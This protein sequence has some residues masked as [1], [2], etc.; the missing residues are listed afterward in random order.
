MTSETTPASTLRADLDACLLEMGVPTKRRQ[1]AVRQ[2]C[3]GEAI[4]LACERL[5]MTTIS[6]RLGYGEHTIRKWRQREPEFNRRLSEALTASKGSRR[7]RVDA[8]LWEKA[9]SMEKGT[10]G[11]GQSINILANL[12]FPELRESKVKAE[13]TGRPEPQAERAA[14]LSLA[15]RN[16]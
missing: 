11:V 10:P 5:S 14:L 15:K 1:E 4:R 13:V 12:E 7:A 8:L 2:V 9:E 6:E 3:Q 16:G